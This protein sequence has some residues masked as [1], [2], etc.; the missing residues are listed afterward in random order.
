MRIAV[1]GRKGQLVSSLLERASGTTHEL[2]PVG[3]PLLDLTSLDT[4]APALMSV[5][6]DL[7]VSAA[8]YTAVDQAEL[9]P[10]LAKAINAEGAGKV[11]EAAAKMGI[12]IIHV[13]TDYVYDG[14]KTSPYVETDLP[15]PRTVYGIT[16][17][18]GE[19][20]VGA[21]N[22]DSVILRLGWLYSPFGRNF[23]RTM[24][25]VAA[26]RNS[27]RVVADQRG[28]PTSGLDVADAILRIGERMCMDSCPALR[29]VFHVS[30]QGEATWAE[31]AARIFAAA[32]SPC[33]VERIKTSKYPMRAARPANSRLSSGKLLQVYG[34][35]LP[36]WTESL[37]ACVKRLGVAKLRGDAPSRAVNPQ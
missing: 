34:I 33:G 6:P 25:D 12:P 31:L 17:L 15:A 37:D 10:A 3:R 18:Q 2:V 28:G 7:I 13:S 20:R 14:A 16:K 22:G 21:A 32:E 24:L 9:E 5:S 11:A 19:V 35:A 8:A 36:H 26:T 23:V 29:G 4:I 27:V 30:P 1:T